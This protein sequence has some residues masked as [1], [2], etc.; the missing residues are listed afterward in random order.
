MNRSICVRA[1]SRVCSTNRTG[2]PSAPAI[3]E[4]RVEYEISEV[5]RSLAPFFAHLTE[6]AATNLSKVEQA[7][8]DYDT[9]PAR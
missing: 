9:R 8:H 1:S 4:A 7:R 6:W 3:A 2:S 5:G